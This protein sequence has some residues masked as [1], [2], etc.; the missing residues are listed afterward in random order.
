MA[1]GAATWTRRKD[2]P[3]YSFWWPVYEL[4]VR[5]LQEIVQGASIAWT[6][7]KCQRMDRQFNHS[8]FG[9]WVQGWDV[10]QYE[11]NQRIFPRVGSYFVSL[12]RILTPKRQCNR[13]A[14]RRSI[15]LLGSRRHR[16]SIENSN[17]LINTR[18]IRLRVLGRGIYRV[19]DNAQ[20]TRS[21]FLWPR[22]ILT[23]I[24]RRT[25]GKLYRRTYALLYTRF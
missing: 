13:E 5:L 20:L 24:P 15:R 23:E 3:Q 6:E 17:A 12:Y 16:K 19:I 1:P 18:Y 10:A 7:F 9:Q 2:W 8:N 22:S 14:V 11:D 4:L 25:L 21:L